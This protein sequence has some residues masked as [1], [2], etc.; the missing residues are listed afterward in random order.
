MNPYN[1]ILLPVQSTKEFAAVRE[2]AAW[3]S[4]SIDAKLITV[5]LSDDQALKA[6]VQDFKKNA[7]FHCDVK[8]LQHV[9]GRLMDKVLGLL[10]EYENDLLILPGLDGNL[11]EDR[12]LSQEAKELIESSVV[13]VLL[14]PLHHRATVPWS[15]ILVPMSGDSRSNRALRAGIDLANILRVPLDIVH[16]EESQGVEGRVSVDHYTDE[17]Y[18]ELPE[19]VDNF[20]SEASPYSTDEEKRLIRS[21]RLV[22]G[23]PKE[24]ILRE[25]RDRKSG[26][27]FVQWRGKFIKGHGRVLNGIMMESGLPV[28][29][30]KAE[31]YGNVRMRL[32]G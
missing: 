29:L 8:E 6:D 23:N 26:V 7:R 20:I 15:S 31:S 14:V 12:M 19:R 2:V 24:E 18:H 3:L 17:A 27:I 22:R 1:S 9:R 4:Y 13:P 32:A 16:V 25:I 5:L 10:D 30:V 28:L 21:F 11:N